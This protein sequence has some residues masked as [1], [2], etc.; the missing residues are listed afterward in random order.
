MTTPGRFAA[1]KLLG[2]ETNASVMLFEETIPAG[3]KSLFHQH[4]DSDEVAWILAGEITFRIGDEVTVGGLGTCA[5]FPRNVPHAWK[6]ARSSASVTAGKSSAQTRFERWR[7]IEPLEETATAPQAT[8][9]AVTLRDSSRA[10]PDRRGSLQW[11]HNGCRWW[12]QRD[13]IPF[14]HWTLAGL[15]G[16]PSPTRPPAGPKG[17][18]QARGWPGPLLTST[19]SGR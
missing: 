5:F 6:N 17:P 3:T 10:R 1:L 9:G 19:E 15:Y 16:P 14:V 8:R 12:P 18:A 11:E 13:T 2:H 7:R 4:R